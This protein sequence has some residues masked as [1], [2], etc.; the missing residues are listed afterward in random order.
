MSRC[1]ELFI[2]AFMGK[3]RKGT[4][5]YHMEKEHNLTQ[6]MFAAFNRR[7]FL[8]NAAAGAATVA[9]SL[10]FSPVNQVFASS[11]TNLEDHDFGLVLGHDMS[12]LQQLESVGRTFSDHGRVQPAERIVAHHGATYIRER[13]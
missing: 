11:L 9:G 10:A 2:C 1:L 12:T 3:T 7:R 8:T 6:A 4:R 13:L 5:K